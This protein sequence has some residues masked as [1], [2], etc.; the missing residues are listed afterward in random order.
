[1]EGILGREMASIKARKVG[2]CELV[3]WRE[4]E[5]DEWQER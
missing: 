5:K 3:V 1:M 2:K 4:Q